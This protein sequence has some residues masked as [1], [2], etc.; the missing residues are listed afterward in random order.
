[1]DQ[2]YQLQLFED[3]KEAL[4]IANDTLYGLEQV[5]GLEMETLHTE[6]VEVLKQVEFGQIVTMHTRLTLHLVDT[7][8]LVSEEKLTK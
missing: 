6:W 2:L 8:N 4:E 1:M 3:E 7:N 5:F